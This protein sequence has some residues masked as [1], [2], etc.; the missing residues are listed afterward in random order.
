[1]DDYCDWEQ[2]FKKENP[3]LADFKLNLLEYID[4]HRL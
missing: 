1:L 4:Y 2:K 3:E